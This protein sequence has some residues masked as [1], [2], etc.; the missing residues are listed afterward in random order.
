MAAEINLHPGG[1]IHWRIGR[2]KTDVRDVSGT[3]ARRDV[4][5]ATEGNRE[6][7]KVAAN[8]AA[9]CKGL[10]SSSGGA[11]MLVA[12]RQVV[13]HEVA[14]GLH[15]WPAGRCVS[16]EAPGIVGQAIGFAVAAA[17]QE[18]QG[19]RRQVLHLVLE[20]ARID[21]IGCSEAAHDS[22]DSEG[23]LARRGNKTAAPVAEAVAI[24][25]YRNGGQRNQ[26]IRILQIGEA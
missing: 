25:L 12:E 2:R 15:P 20:S 23:E 26:A 13:V 6:M 5:A 10:E 18:Q 19:L 24:T 11:G 4:Q 8:A 9:L 1:E 22:I 3:V 14:D 7:G 16:E 17:E 21:R